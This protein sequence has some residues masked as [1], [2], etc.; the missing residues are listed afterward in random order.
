[1]PRT[2]RFG[3]YSIPLDRHR[4]Y[5]SLRGVKLRWHHGAWVVFLSA[6]GAS[7]RQAVSLQ[8]N[9]DRRAL[10]QFYALESHLAAGLQRPD[11]LRALARTSSPR[12]TGPLTLAA[13]LTLFL[14]ESVTRRAPTTIE[15]YRSDLHAW[16]LGRDRPHG[17]AVRLPRSELADLPVTAVTSEHIRTLLRTVRETPTRYGRKFERRTA[18]GVR[19]AL[20]ALFAF[21][22][23]RNLLRMTDGRALSNPCHGLKDATYDARVDRGKAKEALACP[24]A[25]R[26]AILSYFAARWPFELPAVGLGFYAG[27]RIGEIFGVHVEDLRFEAGVITVGR[28]NIRGTIYEGTKN[29]R[30]GE[31]ARR[32]V[33][34]GIYEDLPGLLRT[35]MGTR[36]HGP[37]STRSGSRP[38]VPGDWRERV[39]RPAM[40]ALG[41]PY[42]PHAM[43]HTYASNLLER[44]VPVAEVADL[45]G[46]TL[47]VVMRTYAH[48]INRIKLARHDRLFPSQAEHDG[49]PSGPEAPGATAS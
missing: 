16:I 36:T 26:D 45:L 22:T 19:T 28:R 42:T 40:A 20:S 18:E 37:L 38:V 9:D 21:L 12:P 10:E 1:M 33:R 2:R 7:R 3:R 17:S 11:A 49:E 46:D 24:D 13:A 44:N 32:P 14:E 4:S 15:K 39:W 6:H 23:E 34:M 43:R 25:D 48:V 47:E 30:N 29:T 35:A 41:F 31:P 8:T 5:G 27:L